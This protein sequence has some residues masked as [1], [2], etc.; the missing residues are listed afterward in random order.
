MIHCHRLDWLV[1]NIDSNYWILL[2][3]Q[4]RAWW[5]AFRPFSK[6]WSGTDV[7]EVFDVSLYHQ[8][9]MSSLYCSDSPKCL[10][11]L[12]DCPWIPQCV[13]QSMW[14]QLAS[15][16]DCLDRCLS[17]IC[18]GCTCRVQASVRL[19]KMLR[20]IVCK[21]EELFWLSQCWQLPSWSDVLPWLLEAT[22]IFSDL[23]IS[24]RIRNILLQ[25]GWTYIFRIFLLQCAWIKRLKH[26]NGSTISMSAILADSIPMAGRKLPCLADSIPS[27]DGKWKIYELNH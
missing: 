27:M 10:S 3:L 25:Q 26:P 9:I 17:G 16:V 7:C 1:Y 4:S 6:F 20:R 12:L 23:N 14:I 2:G 18:N 22:P 8:I 21:S 15:S 11:N 5:P 13:R 24:D 19:L